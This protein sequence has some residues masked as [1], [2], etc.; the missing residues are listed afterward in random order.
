M[1]I[2][3]K[4]ALFSGDLGRITD[5]VIIGKPTIPKET[6]DF[7]SLES[8]YG[9]KNHPKRSAAKAKLYREIKNSHKAVI[10]PCFSLQRI[11][12]ILITL[13]DW[14]AEES[15]QERQKIHSED[16]KP[17]REF[18]K[19]YVDSPLGK[20]YIEIFLQELLV[21]KSLKYKK[22]VTDKVHYVQLA[23]RQHLIEKINKWHRLILI[24]SS[25]MLQWGTIMSYLPHVL[26]NPHAS[27]I[28][29]GYPGNDTLAR[30]L[31]DQREKQVYIQ[32]QPTDV[33]CR[34]KYIEWFSWHA[35]HGDL[36][37]Y[38]KDIKKSRH[39]KVALEHWWEQRFALEKSIKNARQHNISV[40]TH[41]PAENE[42]IQL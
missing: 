13:L 34:T 27:L 1:N 15:L 29:T 14:L 20:K 42:T 33:V 4:K 23:E 24:S 16:E 25:G 31:I 8:T 5:N 18:G 38:F 21:G 39:A 19:I 26:S 7:I 30:R 2:D 17:Q 35:D 32:G 37:K 41:I 6:Y 40:T 22:L 12:E 36:M 28:F 10:L 9:G 3:G 11:P